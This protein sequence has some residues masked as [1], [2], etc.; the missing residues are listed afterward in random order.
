MASAKID[1]DDG[2]SCPICLGQFNIPRQLPCAHS[3]CQSCLQSYISTMLEKDSALK[4]IECPMCKQ[5]ARPSRNDQPICQW[6]SLF[7]ANTLL[8][9]MLP[10]K[11]IENRICDA[12]NTEGASVLA[13][14]F[15]AVCEEAMCD[16]CLKVHRKQK[17]LK[18]HTIITMDELVNNPQ[19]VMKFAEGFTCFEHDGEDIKFFCNDHNVACCGTCSFLR[20]K[21]CAKVINLREDLLNVFKQGK[22]DKVIGD[23]KN[24]ETHLKKF[25]EMNESNINTLESQVTRLTNEIAEVR[26]KINAALDDLETRVKKEA[27]RL[28]KEETVIKQEESH[29]CLS[30]MHAVRNS[31]AILETVSRYGIET[32]KFLMTEKMT[33]Q[34]SFY[35]TQIRGKFDNT[36]TV[37]F[38]LEFGPLVESI[39]SQSLCA[40]GKLVTIKS[41]NRLPL[42]DL[43]KPTKDCHVERVDVINVKDP[44]VTMPNYSGI[45]LLSGNR[46][47]LAD[48]NNSKCILLSSSYQLI[49]NF[50]LS[51]KPWD[52]TLVDN[53]EVAVSLLN[54]NKIQILSIRN[55][56]ISPVRTITTK[57]TCCGIANA[58]HNNIVVTGSCDKN[59]YYWSLISMDGDM[60]SFHQFDCSGYY[61]NHV[62]LD[63]D[64][65]RVYV[66]L[67]GNNF[68]VCFDMDGNRQF[69]SSPDN[70]CWSAGVSLDRDDNIYVLGFQSGN[71]HQLS[72]GGS[73]LQVI[74]AGVPQSPRGIYF[75]KRNNLF[76][77]TNLS[78]GNNLYVYQLR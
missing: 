33:S 38:Q 8:Q 48:Y 49:S 70:L 72:P 40:I 2:P 60:K 52:T 21:T 75:D 23:L 53:E 46:V 42:L 30:L 55:D 22:M 64:K 27:N 11:S 77:L 15:C 57:H 18:N 12:C 66:T 71:I 78:D 74:T 67:P 24:V 3:F 32:Q 7:P 6:A 25:Y 69:T 58:G 63:K 5:V 59:K 20:H 39:L 44:V 35:Y 51:K 26:R 76:I 47:M 34:L 36:D 17:I 29:H 62:A 68:L 9:S 28:S 54:E 56:D 50:T 10:K 73:V 61:F 13:N 31:Y 16:E 19:N 45:T 65:T 14:G 1:I 4:Q 43:Q 41:S 37:N